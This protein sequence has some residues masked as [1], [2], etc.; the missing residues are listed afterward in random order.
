VTLI[1]PQAAALSY[2]LPDYGLELFFSP[3][4]FVQVNGEINRAMIA[5]VIGLLDLKPQEHVL[6]LFCGLGNFTLPLARHAGHVTGVEGDARLVERAQSNAQHNGIR[7]AE[8]YAADLSQDLAQ[9]PWAE[10]RFDKI[11]LDPPRTGALEIVRQ[12]PVFGASRIVYVS[13]N[14]ATLARDAQ[15]LVQCGYR[16][17]SAGVMDM[18]PHT[19]HVESI[20]L[21]EKYEDSI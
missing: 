9:Q 19:T 14:P 11:L 10:Q 18:F 4:D 3:A 15:E 12:L 7:N 21:F 5:S 6:D 17:L 1:W 16:L 8:F 20:A 13:C 2:R